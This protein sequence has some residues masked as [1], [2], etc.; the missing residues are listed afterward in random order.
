MFSRHNQKEE[1]LITQLHEIVNTMRQY[2][3]ETSLKNR[4]DNNRPKNAF[5]MRYFDS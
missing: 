2:I 3:N 5:A 4:T 1:K